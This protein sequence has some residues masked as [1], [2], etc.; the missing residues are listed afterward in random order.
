MWA[1]VSSLEYIA[2]E[3]EAISSLADSAVGSV[4]AVVPPQ[5]AA[6]ASVCM[7]VARA[8]PCITLML[9]NHSKITGVYRVSWLPHGNY[10][11]D[12]LPFKNYRSFPRD[13]WF[14]H[15]NYRGGPLPFKKYHSLP[16]WL[17]TTRE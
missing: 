11:D 2:G 9:A 8:L 1:I 7:Y 15:A 17:V 10:R 12:S 16:R 6:S 4:A 14:P 13:D 5:L 3:A